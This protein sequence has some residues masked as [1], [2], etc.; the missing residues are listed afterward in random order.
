MVN[1]GYKVISDGTDNHLLLIDLRPKDSE[2]TGKVA[3]KTLEN[4]DITINKNAV[5]FE[6]RSPLVTSGIRL[7]TPALTT[8]GLKEDQMVFIAEL[9]DRALTHRDKQSELENVKKEVHH[10]MG[11]YPLYA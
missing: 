3:E 2:L 8:R 11:G 4:C 10:L 5:P 6:T 9:I 7:G 1:R